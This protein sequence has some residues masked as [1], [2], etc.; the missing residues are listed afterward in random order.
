MWK[1]VLSAYEIYV[2]PWHRSFSLI[3]CCQSSLWAYGLVPSERDGQSR[4]PHP[5]NHLPVWLY[6]ISR[7]RD[8]NT[9]IAGI[10]F[11]FAARVGELARRWLTRHRPWHKARVLLLRTRNV[12]RI[13][14]VPG[15]AVLARKESVLWHL[16]RRVWW[17]LE[18]L[19]FRECLRMLAQCLL[20]VPLV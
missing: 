6:S 13:V 18:V 10:T 1:G 19:V 5:I 20:A 16:W 3:P 12:R 17:N 8:W 4:Y 7:C 14:C 9:T 15:L 11:G 2:R